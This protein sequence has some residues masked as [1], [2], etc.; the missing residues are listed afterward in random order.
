MDGLTASAFSAI[1]IVT[2]LFASCCFVTFEWNKIIILAFIA[3]MM[4]EAVTSNPSEKYDN[5]GKEVSANP[6]QD[7][8][9]PAEARPPLID[10]ADSTVATVQAV[11]EGTVTTQPGAIVTPVEKFE[12]KRMESTNG[13][14]SII[15]AEKRHIF[16][17]PYLKVAPH[18]YGMVNVAN[19]LI[20][21]VSFIVSIATSSYFTSIEFE[22][23]IFIVAALFYSWCFRSF[24]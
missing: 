1:I 22:V 14:Q 7:Y 13:Y 12:I 19:Q 15:N 4:G 23:S 18:I 3:T 24:L 10:G 20:S 17:I 11:E 5:A 16:D 2:V 9:A 21:F 6:L 8:S